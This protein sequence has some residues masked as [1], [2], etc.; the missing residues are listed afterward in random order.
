VPKHYTLPELLNLLKQGIEVWRTIP[1]WKSYY[2][3]STLG[4]VKSLARLVTERS[5]TVRPLKERIMR[6]SGGGPNGRP[7]VILCKNTKNRR[8][9]YVHHLVLET[10]VGPKPDGMEACH[11]PIQDVGCNRLDNLRWDTHLNNVREQRSWGGGSPG[12]KNGR[13]KLTEDEVRKIRRLYATGKYRQVDLGNKF[14]ITQD[15]VSGII[16]RKTWAHVE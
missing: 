3:V 16:L 14:G 7:M 11:F 6:T 8:R 13:A 10:F 2:K 15:S 5:G 12:E 9:A 1:G 4:R